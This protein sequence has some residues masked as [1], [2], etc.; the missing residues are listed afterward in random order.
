MKKSV[1][2]VFVL[3]FAMLLAA[4][5][6]NARA[7]DKTGGQQEFINWCP[8]E[9]PGYAVQLIK[10][11]VIYVRLEEKPES[12]E[13]TRQVIKDLAESYREYTNDSSAVGI[14]VFA[15]NRIVMNGK[16]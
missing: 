9:T 15:G 7:D 5:A 3:A 2:L 10:P 4:G 14:V 6:G 16:F 12:A 13:E 8:Q 1:I 11:G